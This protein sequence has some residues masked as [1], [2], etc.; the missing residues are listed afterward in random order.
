MYRLM[1]FFSL[2]P[3]SLSLLLSPFTEQWSLEWSFLPCK[4]CVCVCVCGV[5]VCVCACVRVRGEEHTHTQHGAQCVDKAP[6]WGWNLQSYN[7]ERSR[8]SGAFYKESH[9]NKINE[10]GKKTQET[11]NCA[12]ATTRFQ[13]VQILIDDF[14]E[15]K[16]TQKPPVSTKGKLVYLFWFG[17]RFTPLP[18][19]FVVFCV[20]VWL[21]Y[22]LFNLF[23]AKFEWRRSCLKCNIHHRDSL[24][25]M[26]Y[27][28][29][30]TRR[31]ERRL[32][33]G[34]TGVKGE[35]AVKQTCHP[36]PTLANQTDG[37]I[38]FLL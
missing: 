15:G 36:D 38:P 25:G 9:L 13:F 19:C 1:I 23:C 4:R 33:E 24:K 18:F 16:I 34:K 12:F 7:E 31:T 22:W 3:F 32:S 6:V 20:C 37:G 11:K 17:R 10:Y 26:L 27:F 21:I 35:E 14:V 30:E 28:W 2:L 29:V 5:C 8:N